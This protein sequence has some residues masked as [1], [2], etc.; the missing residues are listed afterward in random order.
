MIIVIITTITITMQILT[1]RANPNPRHAPA[2][3]PQQIAPLGRKFIAKRR[4][5]PCKLDLLQG[6]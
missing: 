2:F 1:T 4:L 5:L 6:S 3:L